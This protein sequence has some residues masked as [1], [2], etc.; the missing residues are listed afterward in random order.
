MADIPIVETRSIPVQDG[1]T[2][3]VQMTQPFIDRLRQH[4]GL[5]GDQRLEDEQVKLYVWGAVN[6]AVAKVEHE[7]TEVAQPAAVP[8]RVRR[9]RRRKKDA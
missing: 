4:F 2:L 3:E 1:Q 9:P 6:T 7:I 8:H 5:F